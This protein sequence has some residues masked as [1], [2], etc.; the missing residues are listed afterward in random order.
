MKA[1]AFLLLMVGQLGWAAER[2]GGTIFIPAPAKMEVRTTFHLSHGDYEVHGTVL[3]KKDTDKKLDYRGTIVIT[4]V[5]V[6]EDTRTT[7]AALLIEKK[8]N[9][10]EGALMFGDLIT[11]SFEQPTLIPAPDQAIRAE[12][13]LQQY[14]PGPPGSTIGGIWWPIASHATELTFTY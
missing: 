6:P 13:L 7:R 9:H 2:R 10:A 12:F 3:K 11:I 4:N 1:F 14:D 8:K 5:D